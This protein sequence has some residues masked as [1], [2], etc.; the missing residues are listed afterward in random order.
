VG[1]ALNLALTV[2]LCACGEGKPQEPDLPKRPDRWVKEISLDADSKVTS[3]G[4]RDY[5]VTDA[6]KSK[7]LRGAKVIAVGDEVEGVRI[8]AIKCSFHWRVAIYGGAQF[9]RRGR[10]AC[11]AG[12]SREELEAAVKEDGTKMFDYIHVAPIRL[13]GE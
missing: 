2:S 10:W 4:P 5:F 3:V 6:T 1:S 12:R 7:E 13:R 9:M 8:G 11:M